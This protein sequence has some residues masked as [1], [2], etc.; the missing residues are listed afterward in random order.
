[1]FTVID[2][3]RQVSRLT[4]GRYDTTLGPLIELWGFGARTPESPIPSDEAIT[5]AL[6][7]TGLET[8]IGIDADAQTL[9]KKD[10]SANIHVAS[11]AKGYGIDRVASAIRDLGYTNYMVEIGGDM[12]VAGTKR[13][14]DEWRIGVEKPSQGLAELQTIISF[15]D[16]GMA[17]SGDYRNYFEE[18]GI[19]YSHIIDGQTGRPIT[20]STAAVT[21]VA[22]NAMM[23]DAWATALLV[24]GA[25]EGQKIAEELDLAAYFILKDNTSGEQGF[26]I[27]STSHF[28]SLQDAARRD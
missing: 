12:A 15:T 18:D 3:S 13:N 4:S 27:V 19:R 7:Q 16:K 21:V 25:E 14:G 2:A 5:Q 1:V 11:L 6:T 26:I 23:A 17:S 24:V 10:K 20:H 28:E 22:E 8:V 9:I